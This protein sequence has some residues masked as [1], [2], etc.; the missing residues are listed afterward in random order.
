MIDF[1]GFRLADK[2]SGRL[3]RHSGST[4]RFKNLRDRSHNL[5]R[6]SRILQSLGQMGFRPYKRPLFAALREENERHGSPLRGA[7]TRSLDSF[8]APLLGKEGGGTRGARDGRAT[9]RI[10]GIR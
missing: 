8:W 5:L 4:E 3:E 6:I 1:Y 10:D 7:L 2:S 9:L